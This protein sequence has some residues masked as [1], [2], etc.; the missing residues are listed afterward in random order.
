MR[1][2]CDLEVASGGTSSS[3]LPDTTLHRND[4]RDVMLDTN[5]YLSIWM[6]V[7]VRGNEACVS[8]TKG[9]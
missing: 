7:L 4:C 5:Q 1:G 8:R 2:Q 6:C 9:R 3:G